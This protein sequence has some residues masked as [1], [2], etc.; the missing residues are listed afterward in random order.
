M[1]NS[2]CGRI[3]LWEH[4]VS[5]N[6]RQTN[7]NFD[8]VCV[9][10]PNAGTMLNV[11]AA[12]PR[13]RTKDV[14]FTLSTDGVILNS[15]MSDFFAVLLLLIYISLSLLGCLSVYPS[16]WWTFVCDGDARAPGRCVS[17]LCATIIF[18]PLFLSILLVS[19]VFLHTLRFKTI[20]HSDVCGFSSNI[21]CSSDTLFLYLYWFI[22]QM[23]LINRLI[24]IYRLDAFRFLSPSLRVGRLND[25]I[26]NRLAIRTSMWN[27][28]ER[29]T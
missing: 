11:N 16:V 18:F 28:S 2:K 3:R 20:P 14:L 21:S 24:N 17:Q 6:F 7:E 4:F 10:I 22:G 12:K 27:T 29:E 19:I 1:V 8:G 9:S 25:I 15:M 26:A 13:T 23:A 5:Y